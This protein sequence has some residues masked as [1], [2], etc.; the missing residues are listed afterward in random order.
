MKY[1]EI[2]TLLDRYWEGETSLEE[3]RSLKAYFNAG[4][5]DARLQN[6]APLFQALKE[7]QL[8]EFKSKAKSVS[9]RPQMYQWAVAASVTLLLAAGWWIM[10]QDAPT[11][12]MAA[13]PAPLPKQEMLEPM[14]DQKE[15]ME[16]MATIAP[17]KPIVNKKPA[18]KPVKR[19][20]PAKNAE[21]DPET[22]IA[23]AEIKAALALVSSKL[24]K[25]KKHAVQKASYLEVVEKVPRKKEG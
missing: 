25:G 14:P 5:I 23:M 6:V 7:E 1:E 16:S 2:Q 3:E 18:K 21:P 10:Q 9:I 17:Q 20:T 13:F 24:D 11:V 4:S 22:A 19:N 12:P 15:S 8:I